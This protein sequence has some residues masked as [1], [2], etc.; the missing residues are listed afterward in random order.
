[1]ADGA[2]GG[3]ALR[4]RTCKRVIIRVHIGRDANV[5]LVVRWHDGIHLIRLL[6][7]NVEMAPLAQVTFD[8]IRAILAT[9]QLIRV[10]ACWSAVLRVAHRPGGGDYEFATLGNVRA[11]SF[12]LH[13]FGEA[14]RVD[15]VPNPR[16][17]VVSAARR[18]AVAIV[19]RRFLLLKEAW[20]REAWR[21]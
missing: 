11:S 4:F 19:D 1:M 15:K 3:C 12:T 8:A 16:E 14:K 7:P 18:C 13:V 5:D 6:V 10:L 20:R 17:V 2:N 9:A 21:R